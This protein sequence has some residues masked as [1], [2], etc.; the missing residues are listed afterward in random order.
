M[1]GAGV[2]TVWAPAA[3][4][5]GLVIGLAAATVAFCNATS[6]AQ[7]AALHLNRGAMAFGAPVHSDG[8]ASW[9]FRV[10]SR[11]RSSRAA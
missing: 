9:A 10:T 3:A 8:R 11:R 7:L 2:F 1:I 5:A 6:S 4:V